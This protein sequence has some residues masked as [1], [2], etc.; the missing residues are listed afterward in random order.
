MRRDRC[1][2]G[3]ALRAGLVQF[4]G[5]NHAVGFAQLLAACEAGF[6]EREV[7]PGLRQILFGLVKRGGFGAAFQ[8]EKQLA[9]FHFV[10]A[11][12]G[13]IGERAAERRGDINVFA[14]DVALEFVVGIAGA[15]GEEQAGG[16]SEQVKAGENF[17]ANFAF[18]LAGKYFLTSETIHSTFNL[19]NGRIRAW[20]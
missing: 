3:V 13:E 17:H 15:A 7:G 14:F 20:L 6:R 12:D 9:G 4:L 10:A 18:T 11:R 2:V 19:P 1:C 8:H 5:G 16:E